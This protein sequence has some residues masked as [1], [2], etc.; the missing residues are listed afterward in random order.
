MC[1]SGLVNNGTNALCTNNSPDEEGKTS[2]GHKIG[3]DCEEMPDLFNWEPDCRQGSKPE[4]KEGNECDRVG[5]RAWD[6]IVDT[7]I[8][9]VLESVRKPCRTYLSKLTFRQLL[10]MLRII[11]YTHVPPIHACTPYQIHAMAALL[12]TGQSAPQ[13]PKEERDTTGNEIWYIAPM[14]PVILE[15][16]LVNARKWETEQQIPDETSSDAVPNPDAE[17]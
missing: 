11:R 12:N 1:C 4:Q 15:C 14:R 9:S 6:A 17:P 13:M 7:T 5:S 3:L 10:Q 8:S 2:G 16:R